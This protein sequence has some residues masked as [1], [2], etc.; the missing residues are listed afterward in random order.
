MFIRTF[1]IALLHLIPFLFA[2]CVS[3]RD[4]TTVGTPVAKV[5]IETS[6]PVK[7]SKSATSASHFICWNVHKAGHEDFERDMNAL[8]A[9][10]P[11]GDDVILCLQEAR[12]STYG[13]IRT[14]FGRDFRGH[15]APSWKLPL[16]KGSTGVMTLGT[17]SIG[18]ATKLTSP[19]RELYIGSPK[20][21]LATETPLADGRTLQVLNCH[22]LNFV[23]LSVFPRQLDG[24][25]ASLDPRGGPAIV[26]GDF[27][28]WSQARLD[29]LNRKALEAGLIEA[30][31][32]GPGHS[33]AP[34]WLRGLKRIN[35]FDP[36]LRLDRI[37]TRGIE[38]LDC[39]CQPD[40]RSSDHLP[41]IL[42]YKILPA[43]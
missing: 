25:F 13:R 39:S 29:H 8:V 37:Y 7:V 14:L 15:Y 21:S 30:P 26:C 34:K 2:S 17:G 42:R 41:L 40:L 10:I 36:G 43:S 16:S 4:V 27:N 38:V 33:P 9:A 31:L 3:I 32:T 18:R 12:G 23:P 22:G 19:R 28:V 35:G 5:R 20:V 1:G 6:A 11:A 24:I